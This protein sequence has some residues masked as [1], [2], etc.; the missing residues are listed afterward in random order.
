LVP[1]GIEEVGE[2][3]DVELWETLVTVTVPRA[4]DED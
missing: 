3:V 2:F 1:C 4:V